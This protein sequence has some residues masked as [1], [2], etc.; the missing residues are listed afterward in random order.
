MDT[1]VQHLKDAIRRTWTAGDFG[2]IARSTAKGAAE[3]VD[4]LNIDRGARVLDVACGTGNTAIP[5]ARKGARVTGLD[6][7][8][9]LLEQARRRAAD[10]GA[11]ATF[12]EGDAEHLP[13]PD[14]TFDV[15]ISMFGAMFGPRPELIAA[16]LARVCRPGGII[17]MAN[18]TPNGFTGEM[19]K[20]SARHVPPPQGIPAPV[21][22]GEESVVRERLGP[23]TSNIKTET[24]LIEMSYPLSPSAVV[25][26]YREYFGPTKAGFAKLD[27]PGQAAYARDMEAMWR[28]HNRGTEDHVSV[29]NE[30]L[31]VIATR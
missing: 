14:A 3:F 12:E 7:A 27:E 24:R 1:G 29:A 18:W 5:A 2:Q 17:A 25:G 6:L 30:Y 23:L 21:L 15:V 22:W 10:E 26:F 4:R 9:N 31:E 13:F 11:E 20:V 16:E 8:P 28:K 19:F